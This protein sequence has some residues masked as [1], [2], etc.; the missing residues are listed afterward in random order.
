MEQGGGTGRRAERWR[1]GLMG[2]KRYP[3]DIRAKAVGMVL[4]GMTMSEAAHHIGCS[5]RAIADWMLT[6]KAEA[7]YHGTRDLVAAG[8]A[9]QTLPDL[10][11]DW[12]RA[13]VAACLAIARLAEH[14][15]DWIRSQ[16]ARD[17]AVLAGVLSDKVI[18]VLAR[19]LDA[20]AAERERTDPLPAA[21]RRIPV[22]V[23]ADAEGG[24]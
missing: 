11:E 2:Q 19:V 5:R 14:N 9:R 8:V 24:V 1:R 21:D 4:G 10:I 7:A 23:G 13:N 3:A 17:L 12:I 16:G 22:T 6:A 15:S 20:Q 18:V